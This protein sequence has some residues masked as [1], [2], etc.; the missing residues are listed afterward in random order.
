MSTLSIA[1]LIELQYDYC[2]RLWWNTDVDRYYRRVGYLWPLGAGLW[3][4]PVTFVLLVGMIH[5]QRIQRLDKDVSKTIAVMKAL[6]SYIEN[7]I[8]H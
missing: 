3:P 8:K 6:V 2:D 5:C 1:N 4:V 7:E